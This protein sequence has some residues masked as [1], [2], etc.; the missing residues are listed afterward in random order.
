MD[1]FEKSDVISAKKGLPITVNEVKYTKKMFSQNSLV[2]HFRRL[3]VF[4]TV[5]AE[6][7]TLKNKKV[8]KWS[9]SQNAARATLRKLL[10][11]YWK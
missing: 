9:S 1:L 4:N 10:A 8:E 2:S 7:Q 5:Q 11:V 6:L 3:K